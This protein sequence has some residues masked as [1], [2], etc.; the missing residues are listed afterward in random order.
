MFEDVDVAIVGAGPV[1]TLMA[2]LL[3]RHGLRVVVLERESTPHGTPRAFSCDDEAMRVYQQAGLDHELSATTYACPEAAFTDA[4]GRA[5]AKL[6]FRGLDFGHGFPAL[7]FFH[8]PTLEAILRRGLARFEGVSLR[9][10]HEVLAMDEDAER[11]RLTMRDPNGE[12]RDLRARYVLGCDGRKSTIRKLAGIAYEGRRYE[13]PWIA[14]SGVMDEIPETMPLARF[15]CDP[16]RPG[17]VAR[18][19]ENQCRM[20]FMMQ[21]GETRESIEKPTS[22]ARLIAPYVDP[23][24]IRIQRA[25]VYTFEAKTATQW[26]KGRFFLLGDA[27]HTMPPF[28]GQGLVSGLRDA[29]N[30]AWKLA[31]CITGRASERLLDT[32]E[33]ERRPHLLA[34]TEIS[35]RLGHVFL[36][37]DA[38]A[39]AVRDVVF[40]GLDRVSR[41]RKFIRDMEFKPKPTCDEGM[42]RGGRRRRGR[43]DGAPG[44]VPRYPEGTYFPQPFVRDASGARMRLDDTFGAGFAV[45]GFGLDPRERIQDEPFWKGLGTQFFRVLPAGSGAREGALVDEDGALERWFVRYGAALVIVR[46]DRYVF[47]GFSRTEAAQAEG[48]LRRA[49]G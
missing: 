11:A 36:V 10:G 42:M 32:Y 4:S 35:I 39:A 28:M 49:L 3:G 29:A 20:E 22:I 23:D 48:A 1:G 6:V 7:N 24:K 46:P 9:L 25:S 45:L 37:R 47:G 30:L 16:A 43:F 5:F 8:Q 15:V 31:L 14:I 41:V 40:R 33:R 19:T 26:R 44:V 2:N 17:F 21:P 27:A 34:M 12:T 38:R 13:E 18:G